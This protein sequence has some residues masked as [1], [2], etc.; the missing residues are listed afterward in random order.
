MKLG[1]EG[2]NAVQ[3]DDGLEAVVELLPGRFLDAELAGLR[4]DD[5]IA[6]CLL[7]SIQGTIC[8][9]SQGFWVR[10]VR[11]ETGQTLAGRDLGQR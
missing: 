6:A 2:G 3:Q 5:P 9:L 8:S 7:G 11:G 1:I 10:G 4:H